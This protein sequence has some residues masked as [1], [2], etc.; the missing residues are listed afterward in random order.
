M[1]DNPVKQAL[2]AGQAQYG[3]FVFDFAVPGLP[4]I[5]AAAGADFLIYDLEH[6]GLGEADVKAQVAA[7]RGLSVTPFVRPLQK[8]YESVAR[9]LDLGALGLL[10]PMVGSAEQAARIVSWTRYPPAGVRG[11]AFGAAHDDYRPGGFAEKV[12]VADRRTLVMPMIETPDGLANVEAIAAVEGVDVPFI[13]PSDLS[14][15]VGTPGAF[16]SKPFG[17]AVD[18]ILAACEAAGKPAGAF[19]GSVDWGRRLVAR[20]FKVICY[21]YD[22]GLYQKALTADL[23]D[24]RG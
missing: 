16:D 12:A 23:A 7:C 15:A 8:T 20:G 3:T 19:V 10:L 2:A 1:R 18:R 9:L 13:G 14:F 21:H 4:A 6:S 11:A 24:L 17:Q 5:A 22:A